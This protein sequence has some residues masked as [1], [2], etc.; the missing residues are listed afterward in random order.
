MAD[1]AQIFCENGDPERVV[2]ILPAG[3]PLNDLCDS[4]MKQIFTAHGYKDSRYGR[5]VRLD[6]STG[7]QICRYLDRVGLTLKVY[8][9]ESLIDVIRAEHQSAMRLWR[10]ADHG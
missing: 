5:Y 10:S 1:R 9:H 6:D 4:E 2:R 8:R 3:H 7:N